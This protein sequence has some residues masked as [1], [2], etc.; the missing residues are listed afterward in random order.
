MGMFDRIFVE[1]KLPLPKIVE[2]L[3][4]NWKKEEFQTKDLDNLMYSYRISKSGRLMFLDQKTEWVKDNSRFGGHIN[5]ISECWLK[6][7]HTGK[8]FFYTTVCS[9][10]DQKESEWM[11]FVTQDQ[12]DGADGFDYSLDF[13]A[14]FVDG[15]LK[16]LKLAKFEKYPIK[17]Y[18]LTH[19]KWV[20]GIKEK[21]ARLSFKIKSF[22]KTVIP[23][24]GYYKIINYLNK[25]IGFQQK[26]ITKLY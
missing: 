17:E 14:K 25:L 4:I 7:K 12:I 16:T 23:N 5:V 3:K 22:F 10:P 11:E 19:N 2:N 1:V 18:L 20:E 15:V 21:E 13:E 9:N 6:S 26:I 8:V 24:R